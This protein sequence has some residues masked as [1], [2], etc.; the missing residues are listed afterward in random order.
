MTRM[1]P[2]ERTLLSAAFDVNLL[3]LGS[4]TVI[5]EPARNFDTDTLVNARSGELA[6]PR[7]F[8]NVPERSILFTIG[9]S[10][11]KSAPEFGDQNSTPRFDKRTER[12]SRRRFEP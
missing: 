7:Y 9:S 4:R 1:A 2:V 10:P 6:R 11:A 5:R 8:C 3:V 12:T